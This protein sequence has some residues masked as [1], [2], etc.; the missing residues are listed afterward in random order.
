MYVFLAIS[1]SGKV[2]QRHYI[3]L[4]MDVLSGKT[5]TLFYP[6]PEND[7]VMFEQPSKS[8]WRKLF[9]LVELATPLQPL[10]SSRSQPEGLISAPVFNQGNI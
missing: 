7:D 9:W 4:F 1:I 8:E 5:E 2:E 3:L 10:F 6:Q